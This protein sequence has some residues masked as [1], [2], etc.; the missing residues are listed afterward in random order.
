MKIEKLRNK[1][2]K[3]YFLCGLIMVVLLTVTITFIT[4]KANYRMT[5]S[6]P[7]TE[8]KVIASPYDINI[9]ALYLDNVEQ[10]SN[11]LIPSGYKINESQS[12][13]Y[14]GT[15]K[16]NKDSNAKL[17]T[18]ILGE[19]VFT[20]V[21]KSSKC[22]LYLDKNTE[23][24]RTMTELL[25]THYKYKSKRTIENKDFNVPYGETTYGM[26]FEAEDDDGISYY[27]AGNPLDNWV[28][29]GGYYWRIIRINGDGSIRIIYQGRTQDENGNR[30]EPQITGEETQIKIN[31]FNEKADD[32]AY[33]G[34]M[35]GTPNSST[36][37]A[38]HDNINDSTV[39]K[40]LDNWFI[41]S[42]LKVGTPNIKKIDLNA[43]FCGDR[44]PT[45]TSN[46]I[47]VNGINTGN[48]SG[49]A[50]T[51]HTGYG[52]YVRLRP[53]G[54]SPTPT[55][56]A[57]TPTLKCGNNNDLYTYST[58][59]KGNKKLSTPV[60]MI[61]ADEASYA[62]LA[63]IE[64][65]TSNYLSTNQ[66]YWTISPFNFESI[67]NKA[68]M[69]RI[70]ASGCLGDGAVNWNLQTVRHIRPVINLR[71][72]VEFTGDGTQSNPLKVVV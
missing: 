63:Y 44:T 21:S 4:S 16:N 43:G 2:F 13:C 7:L 29:F 49:G 65:S 39:K 35:Y 6:I 58:S 28:E 46:P 9:V 31:D 27:F 70:D 20:S 17:Y 14:K 33:V 11:T 32:N 67:E 54:I 53:N 59:N 47:V 19:H 61:T 52:A 45:T 3:K 68:R 34:F 48:G 15:N 37:K 50:G 1:S 8:G 64:S 22:I 42:N 10:D 72:D 69:F 24:S 12:Y 23:N 55:S 30:L 60:G 36:Y 51:T 57:V 38:T 62:G 41:N 5:A 56:T 40:A 26:I 18:N 71:A 25:N 66:N